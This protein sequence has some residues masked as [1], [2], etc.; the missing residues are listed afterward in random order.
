[1]LF[2]E[3]PGFESLKVV[4]TQAATSGHIAHAQ[5]FAGQPGSAALPL[6]LA[7]TTY[8]NCTDRTDT[9]SCG[10]CPSCVKYGKLAHPDLNF[11]FPVATSK[12][13]SEAPSS[14]SYIKQF[15]QFVQDQPFG[16]PQEWG[17]FFGAENKQLNISVG[18]ARYIISTLSLKPYEAKW[19]VML[20]WLPEFMNLG[21]ANAILK[22]LEEPTPD[23]LFI[24]VSE[25][26]E[27]LLPTILSR[28]QM[29]RVPPFENDQV[30]Q[31]L[32]NHAGVP[33]LEARTIAMLSGGSLSEARRLMQEDTSIYYELFTSWMR[34][35]Y[36]H[37]YPELLQQTE[38]FGKLGR[39]GQKGFFQYALSMLRESLLSHEGAHDL[40][41][42]PEQELGFVRKF[43]AFIHTDN[44]PDILD[45]LGTAWMHIERNAN[46]KIVF[47]DTS[48]YLCQLLR[49]PA[50]N[51]AEA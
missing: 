43:S 32:I 15:R 36:A 44:M 26:I 7:Y 4:L 12:E 17:A 34:S 30:E 16:G 9:D 47:F 46:A 37:K 13:V 6:A 10:K 3:I 19:K 23:T 49:L 41:K 18:E 21:A 51:Y 48:L 33:A 14:A 39:E 2:A 38:L 50:P 20:I 8:I 29:I 5:L 22:V 42:L 28:V 27:K 25:S 35:C 1:M 11:V 24:L 31:F 45:H 40:V